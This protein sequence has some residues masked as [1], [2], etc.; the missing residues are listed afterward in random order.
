MFCFLL[1]II[2]GLI[3]SSE[4]VYLRAYYDFPLFDDETIYGPDRFAYID[5]A[6]S[7]A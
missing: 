3:K 2:I 5:E 7:R 6:M 4:R 1:S